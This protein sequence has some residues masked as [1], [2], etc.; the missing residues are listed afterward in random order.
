LI[1]IKRLAGAGVIMIVSVKK[2]AERAV[3][4]RAE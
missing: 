1:P 2:A 3:A 4:Q